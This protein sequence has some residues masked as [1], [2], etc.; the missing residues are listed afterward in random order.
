MKRVIVSF[1]LL[2]V[3]VMAFPAE[4]EVDGNRAQPAASE[5]SSSISE[6]MD[7][8]AQSFATLGRRYT[9]LRLEGWFDEWLRFGREG[10]QP[11]G[12]RSG[13]GRSVSPSAI[14]SVLKPGTCG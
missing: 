3:A 1:L 2:F 13:N 14:C 9:D 12:D 6:W 7:G 8:A 10:R 11:G 4:R 5:S